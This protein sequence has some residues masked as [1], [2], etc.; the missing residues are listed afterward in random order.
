MKSKKALESKYGVRYS[1]LVALPYF[2]PIRFTVVDPMHNLYLGTGKHMFKVWIKTEI[3]QK[4]HLTEI[5]KLVKSFSCP[6]GIGRL[7]NKMSSNYGNLNGE[8]G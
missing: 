5:D 4:C 8:R 1:I 7:P 6:V 2:D 3:I